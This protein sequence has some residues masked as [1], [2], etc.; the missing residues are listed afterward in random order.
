MVTTRENETSAFNEYVEA[1][2]EVI[3][4]SDRAEPPR[5][6]CIGLMMPVA[7]QSGEPLAEVT[8]P[9]LVSAKH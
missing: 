2:L 8:A 1:L 4:H 9:A 3:E 7:H 6:Y 5:D